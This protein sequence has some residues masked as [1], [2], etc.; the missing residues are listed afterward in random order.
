M[1]YCRCHL[2]HRGIHHT[3]LKGYRRRQLGDIS[4]VTWGISQ[5]SLTTH[6]NIT[7]VV[8]QVG[9]VGVAPRSAHGPAGVPAVVVIHRAIG[10]V[11]QAAERKSCVAPK[12]ARFSARRIRHASGVVVAASVSQ[13]FCRCNIRVTRDE[14]E[15]GVGGVGWGGRG[16][17]WV[18][19]G[20]RVEVRAFQK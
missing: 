14:G 9:G 6:G 13:T 3:S 8:K 5:T 1:E 20:Y 12:Q 4:D 16:L 19:M 2:R 7:E 18:I 11:V 17:C 10:E 15:E